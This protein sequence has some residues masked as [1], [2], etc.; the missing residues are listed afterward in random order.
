MSA[1]VAL[2]QMVFLKNHRALKILRLMCISI[3]LKKIWIKS[4]SILCAQFLSF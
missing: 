4:V 3:L 1:I 2:F